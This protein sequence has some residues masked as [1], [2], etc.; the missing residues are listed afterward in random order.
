M[1]FE[2][3]LRHTKDFPSSS[4]EDKLV[5]SDIDTGDTDADAYSD[6][7]A[8]ILTNKEWGMLRAQ[9][10]EIQ[11]DNEEDVEIED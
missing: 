11:D 10:L 3:H 8:T 4:D 7:E 5:D 6:E 2:P 1:H 9:E